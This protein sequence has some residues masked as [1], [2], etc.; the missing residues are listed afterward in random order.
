MLIDR[1]ANAQGVLAKSG[2]MNSTCVKQDS[3]SSDK[4]QDPE[5]CWS[6]IKPTVDY[7]RVWRC[8]GDVHVPYTKRSKLNDKSYK[9]VLL[10]YNDESKDYKLFDPITKRIVISRYVMFDE[11]ANWN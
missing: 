11:D 9:C 3:Y 1:E 10:G 6:G 8:I 5:E 7:F 2:S 4:R